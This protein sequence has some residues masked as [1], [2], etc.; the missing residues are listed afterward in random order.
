MEPNWDNLERMDQLT[1][2]TE[3]TF[4]KYKGETIGSVAKYD[5]DYIIYLYEQSLIKP[6]SELLALIRDT[7]KIKR[8]VDNERFNKEYWDTI[9]GSRDE[10]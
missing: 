8:R 4:G 5:S 9:F 3:L 7:I 1:V 2:D 10:I 6:D